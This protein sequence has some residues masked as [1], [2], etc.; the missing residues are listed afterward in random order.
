MLSAIY[1]IKPEL[2]RRIGLR[3]ARCSGDTASALT[4]VHFFKKSFVILRLSAVIK[5]IV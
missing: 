4:H 5:V 2:G 3:I 1:V